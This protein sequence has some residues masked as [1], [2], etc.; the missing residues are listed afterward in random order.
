MNYLL[1]IIGGL[2]CFPLIGE[3]TTVK[4]F[5]FEGLCES[6]QSIVHVRCLEKKSLML[7]D[8]EG[9]FTQY[10]F[11][12]VERIKGDTG[13]ELV[14]VLPGGHVD[15][16]HLEVLGMPKFVPGQETVLFLSEKD[17]HGSPWPVGLGQGCY[18]IA[19]GEDGKR[20]VVFEGHHPKVA[21]LRSKPAFQNKV[22]LQSFLGTIREV[23][24]IEA[25]DE[26]SR[27]Q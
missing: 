9:V 15:G 2:L 5:A 23:L 20:Q 18:G 4:P 26:D 19:V 12:V 6:A 25:V 14:L 11:D 24:K 3:S 7:P 10:R 17:A 22:A 27:K 21:G 13:Q 16:R 1:Y 8:R